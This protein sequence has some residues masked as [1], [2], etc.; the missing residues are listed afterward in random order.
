M[1]QDPITT[2]PTS[3]SLSP[4]FRLWLKIFGVL[5]A[6]SLILLLLLGDVH[7]PADV[8]SILAAAGVLSFFLSLGGWLG[9]RWRHHWRRAV[10]LLACLA[11]AIALFYTEEDWR[12]SHAWNQF[13]LQAEAHGV[14]VDFASVVPQ[15]VPAD[16]YFALTPLV[17]SSYAQ[18]IDPTG[19]EIRP[20]LTNV[21]NRLSMHY[22]LDGDHWDPAKLIEWMNGNRTDLTAMQQYYRALA[23]KTNNPHFSSPAQSPAVDILQALSRFD[24]DIEELRRD[25]QLPASRFPLEY[26][27]ENPAMIML[28]HLAALKCAAQTL[29]L[30][31]TAELATGGMDQALADIK[32]SLRLIES[33]HSEPFLITH[34]V[35]IAMLQI[36]LQP[37]WEGLAD[38]RWNG[39]QLADLD[40][41][42]GK[43]DFLTDYQTGMR[44]DGVFVDRE[45][46]Y[47]RRHPDQYFDLADNWPFGPKLVDPK[48]DLAM[49]IFSAGHLVPHGWYEQNKLRYARHLADFYQSAVDVT[50]RLFMPALIRQGDARLTNE[51]QH[52][53][54]CNILE[55]LFLQ[56]PMALEAGIKFAHGQSCL[57]LVRVAIA[58]ERFRLDQGKFP[59]SLDA[60][61]PQYLNP[62]PRDLIGGKPLHYRL[63]PDGKFV[64]Y[65]IG[66]NER[67]DG[68]V[69]IMQNGSTPGPD[70]SQGDWVWRYPQN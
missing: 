41:E 47:V 14:P 6:I 43:L 25:S 19:H 45:M 11:T 1:N 46:E 15:P 4:G 2:P 33:V 60:L 55:C 21:V 37:V 26:D 42:F 54:P 69:V 44:S 40:A 27:K 12:G 32:L 10:F 58:L 57:D 16:L 48:S 24:A 52:L 7:Q 53:S 13:Q 23:V 30:R 39:T 51:C 49:S 70:L 67:D 22:W 35:R 3:K 63:T 64:L 38:H 18:M 68:G 20:H 66:W 5:L 61:A 9:Y 28:P 34:L 36:T 8:L 56:W 62:V 29:S 17:A 50:N 31:A 65:S 59:D